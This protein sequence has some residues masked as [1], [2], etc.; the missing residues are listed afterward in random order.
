MIVNPVV[1]RSGNLFK[2]TYAGVNQGR[3]NGSP[4]N[5][6]ESI[7]IEA[8]VLVELVAQAAGSEFELK[9]GKYFPFVLKYD[10]IPVVSANSNLIARAPNPPGYFYFNMPNEDLKYIAYG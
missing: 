9:S 5:E 8:G 10:E 6:N 3:V 7:E 4:I 2:F 1:C